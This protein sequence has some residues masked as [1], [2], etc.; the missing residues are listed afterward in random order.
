MRLVGRRARHEP[1]V[2]SAG[3]ADVDPVEV[4]RLGAVEHLVEGPFR[5]DALR[6]EGDVRHRA[7]AQVS[8]AI[9]VT[10]TDP[11]LGLTLVVRHHVETEYLALAPGHLASEVLPLADRPAVVRISVADETKELE[12]LLHAERVAVDGREN[13]GST[14][15]DAGSAALVARRGGVAVVAGRADIDGSAGAEAVDEGRSL[16]A[17]VE[18]VAGLRGGGRRSDA[19]AGSVEPVV[20][21]VDVAVVAG[22]ADVT[23][24]SRCRVAARAVRATVVTRLEKVVLRDASAADAAGLGL[25][26]VVVFAPLRPGAAVGVGDTLGNRDRIDVVVV[27]DDDGRRAVGTILHR[28]GGPVGALD[29]LGP[30]AVWECGAGRAVE[31]VKSVLPVRPVLHGGGGTVAAGDAGARAGLADHARNALLPGH[32]LRTAA[33]AAVHDADTT[34]ATIGVGGALQRLGLALRLSRI[35]AATRGEGHDE[36]HDEETNRLGQRGEQR[37][38]EIAH[39]I[40]MKQKCRSFTSFACE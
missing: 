34:F 33:E 15:A 28:E 13:D 1:V 29:D 23:G 32:A 11:I 5:V 38:L 16:R 31:P 19:D 6:D 40:S 25:I 9:D 7:G 4:G 26:E 20:G 21:G 39:G 27:D 10:A 22:C 36:H 37:H 8:L 30:V 2:P 14:V 17:G 3:R 12:P 35:G 24:R 18:V